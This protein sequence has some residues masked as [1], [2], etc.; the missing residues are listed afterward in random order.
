MFKPLFDGMY[1]ILNFDNELCIDANSQILA[2][3]MMTYQASIEICFEFFLQ[4]FPNLM[5]SY[6]AV[7]AKSAVS[8]NISIHKTL[9]VRRTPDFYLST[10]SFYIAPCL[11]HDYPPTISWLFSL[12]RSSF[13]LFSSPKN[14]IIGLQLRKVK[15][16]SLCLCSLQL[17]IPTEWQKGLSW[18]GW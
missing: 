4:P 18:S 14:Q 6:S 11:S 1:L 10:W 7:C 2:T 15:R 13:S 16:P 8:I 5:C 17:C 3:R 9:P 12:P